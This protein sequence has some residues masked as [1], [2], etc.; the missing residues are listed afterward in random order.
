VDLK[1]LVDLMK[2]AF[3][4]RGLTILAV[5]ILVAVCLVVVHMGA[6]AATAVARFIRELRDAGT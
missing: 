5:L 6:D 4:R 3:G 1:P 2:E